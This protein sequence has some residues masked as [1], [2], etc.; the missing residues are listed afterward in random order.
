MRTPRAAALLMIAGLI[1]TACG[2]RLPDDVQSKAQNAVLNANSGTTTGGTTTGG[3]TT[4]GTTAGGTTTGTTT[5]GTTTGG[6]TAGG[7]TTG[8]TTTRG[9]KGHGPKAS[10]T[11]A[12]APACGKGTDVGLTASDITIGTISDV[13]GPVSGLFQGA[14]QGMV[15]FA[16]YVNQTQGG[17]CGHHINVSFRDGGTNCTQTQNAASDLVNKVFAFVGTFALYDNC[18]V[19]VIK[20]HPTV[21]DIHVALDP[22]AEV[23]SNHYDLTPGPLGYATGMF[24]Y[25]AKKLGSKVQHVGTIAEALPSAEAKQRAITN[26][27]KSQGWK[28]VYEQDEQP[29]NSNFQ[30]DFVK[31]CQQQHIQVFFTVTE[32][33]ANAAT[34]IQNERQAGCPKDLVNV[35]PIAYDQAFTDAFGSNTSAI[36]GLLGYNEYAL[37]FNEDEQIPEVKLFQEWFNRTYPNQP[38][39]LYAMYAWADGRMFQQAV[40]NAG[41]TLNR[42][43]VSAALKK[44]RNFSAN[45]MLAPATPSSKTVGP[46]CYIVWEFRNGAFHRIGTPPINGPTGGFRCDGRFLRS[47]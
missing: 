30:G 19:P 15:T 8:G 38:A 13:T 27:A 11:Q 12:A 43:T 32:N 26:A 18:A 23:P 28:F 22:A 35:I 41:Q 10:Q 7:T 17:I 3:T 24:A 25:L 33:A 9:T 40:E 16:N 14:Q 36:D 20:A 21:P 1:A 46:H 31:M 34:M 29:T 39:N 44:I 6:T 42:K 5:G 37:F 2:A 45:G 47:S 4:G